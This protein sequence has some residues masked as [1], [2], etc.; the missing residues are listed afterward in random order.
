M[1]VAKCV[2]SSPIFVPAG[3]HLDGKNST[4]EWARN[5]EHQLDHEFALAQESQGMLD[6]LSVDG[7]PHVWGSCCTGH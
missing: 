3:T 6:I 2:V 4:G 7:E 1:K 5:G